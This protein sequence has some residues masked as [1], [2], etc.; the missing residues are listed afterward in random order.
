MSDNS[1]KQ[2]LNKNILKI[3]K[4]TSIKNV[5]KM[6]NQIVLFQIKINS[7]K[8]KSILLNIVRVNLKNKQIQNKKKN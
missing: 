7:N 3:I 5:L 8:N 4:S 6:Y 1:F 2:Y